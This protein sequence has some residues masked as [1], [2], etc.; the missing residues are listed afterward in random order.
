MREELDAEAWRERRRAREPAA[1][2]GRAAAPR[3]ASWRE[4][5]LRRAARRR[6]R[7]DLRYLTGFTGSNGLALVR[8][9][10]GR[11]GAAPRS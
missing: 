7:I 3:G 4:R 5:E 11:D 2:A 1:S 9:S 6:S 10:A 8:A